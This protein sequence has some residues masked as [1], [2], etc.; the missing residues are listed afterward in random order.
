MS[1]RKFVG[2]ALGGIGALGILGFDGRTAGLDAGQPVTRVLGGTGIH[3]PVVNMGVMNADNPALVRRAYEVGMRLF[4]TA[5]NYQRGRNEEMVGSVIRELGGRKQTIIATKVYIPHQQRNMSPEQ[6]RDFY[7]KS[8]AESLKRLQTDYIDILYSHNVMTPEYL[9]NPGILE[10]L[11]Q[12]KKEGKARF[13][14]FSTHANMAEL[15]ADATRTGWADVILTVFNYAM[16]DDQ[17]LISS[18]TAASAKGIA[19]IA[20]KTQCSQYWYRQELPAEKQRFYEGNISHGAVLKWA[21]HHPFIACAIPGFTTFE[22]LETDWAAARDLEYSAA[23]KQ[24]ITD[25]QVKLSLAYCRQCAAC[26]PTCPRGVN[27]PE[28]MRTHLYA[29]G[30]G[31]LYQVRDT[32]AE[33]PRQRSLPACAGCER[34]QA[35]CVNG[36]DITGRLNELKAILA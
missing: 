15:I 18:L 23:E 2:R 32:Y 6:A 35:R 3:L 24:F 8:T 31:N 36:I 34:C 12:V 33:I 21:L 29:A 13:I 10:A 16:A 1:R 9:N 22:Q 14:G 30:Y 19:L 25:R 4:D 5:A 27:L 11:Q 28:L 26:L 17:Q 7:I 20:M